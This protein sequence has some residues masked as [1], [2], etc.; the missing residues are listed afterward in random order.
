M[1]DIHTYTESVCVHWHQQLGRLVLGEA[2]TVSTNLTHS[3]N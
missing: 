1:C 3:S 2:V